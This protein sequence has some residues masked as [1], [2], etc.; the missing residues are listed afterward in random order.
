ME[1]AVCF[2]NGKGGV[3]KTSICANVAGI[4]AHTGWRVLA[5]DLDH[6]ANLGND[7][8]FKGG[9]NDDDGAGLTDAVMGGAP[10]QPIRR[11]RPG[12][13]VIPGGSHL[14]RLWRWMGA[15]PAMRVPRLNT[16]LEGLARAYDVVMIDSPPAGGVA[17]DAA[18]AAS[19][20]LVIPVKADEASLDGLELMS[21]QFANARR[22]NPTLQLAG[23]AMFDFSL[24]GTA[25]R[26][27]VRRELMQ[28]LDGIAPVYR[29]FI[30]RS[31]RSAVDMRRGG[32]LAHEYAAEASTQR[33]AVSVADRIKASRSGKPVKAYS[34][35]AEGL[36]EDYRKLAGEILLS[37]GDLHE[38]VKR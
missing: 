36:A 34:T 37:L 35:A 23:V 31:E 6:Q 15:E 10:L 18:L 27:E 24:Q 1:H 5:I 12:L 2:G 13:D 33:K 32:A 29:S 28:D 25:I 26:R 21:R 7:L 8:G 11:V 3:G 16:A 19:Q 17:V 9:R 22:T 14:T 20:W 30:R 4:A 38:R